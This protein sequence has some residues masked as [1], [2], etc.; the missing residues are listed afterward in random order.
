MKRRTGASARPRIINRPSLAT[1]TSVLVGIL[2]PPILSITHLGNRHERANHV[3]TVVFGVMRVKR[4]C[5]TSFRL[6]GSYGAAIGRKSRVL[7]LVKQSAIADLERFRCTAAVPVIGL[8][9]FEDDF[10]LQAA[11]CLVG[12]LLEWNWAFLRNLQ[13]KGAC[14]RFGKI[15]ADAGFR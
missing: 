15:A 14:C 7:D 10:T 8:Q 5:N 9:N 6:H 1:R 4:G 12:N 11:H 13:I 3:S 2:C